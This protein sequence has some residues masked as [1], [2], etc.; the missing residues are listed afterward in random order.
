M[1]ISPLEIPK[2]ARTFLEA[3]RVGRLATVDQSGIPLIAPICFQLQGNTLLTV[4]DDMPTNVEPVRMKGVENLTTNPGMAVVVDRWEEN[5][6]RLAWVLLR[7]TGEVLKSPGMEQRNAVSLL[8]DKYPQYR[9][10]NL[11]DQPVIRM[12]ILAVRHWGDLTATGS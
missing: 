5:W 4:V 7:G 9:G 3:A 2:E 11:K 10:M 12:T 1:P 6:S 8:R